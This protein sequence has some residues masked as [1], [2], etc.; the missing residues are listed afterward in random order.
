MGASRNGQEQVQ[1]KRKV[2]NGK[3]GFFLVLD[4]LLL[5]FVYSFFS[6]F[7]YNVELL[8][9]LNNSIVPNN[10]HRMTSP[11]GIA[12]ASISSLYQDSSFC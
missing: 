12:T 2:D 4:S 6:S 10:D 1:Q 3:T 8:T 11:P 5:L 9:S 7:W